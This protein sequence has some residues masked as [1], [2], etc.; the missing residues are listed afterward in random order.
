MTETTDTRW[1]AWVGLL[2]THKRL[3]A[4]LERELEITHG[5]SI[6]GFELLSRL[7]RAPDRMMRLTVLAE[8]AGISLGRVSRIL[9][10]LERLEL[11]ERR[12]DSDDT[13][14]KN[15][16]LT[17]RGLSVF[18][19]ARKTHF[20]GVE[21]LFFNHVSERDIATLARVFARFRR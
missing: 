8:D 13:R 2:E 17:R 15:A 9:D 4:E 21:Q 5:I 1:A 16:H 11:V 20:A 14:A 7:S 12:G 19:A 3:T 6:S 10:R 18:R